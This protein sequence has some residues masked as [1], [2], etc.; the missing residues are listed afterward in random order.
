MNLSQSLYISAC[1]TLYIETKRTNN[2]I[3]HL[4]PVCSCLRDI[5]KLENASDHIDHVSEDFTRR[6]L[7]QTDTKAIDL[8]RFD[9]RH[10]VMLQTLVCR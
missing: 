2:A 4:I 9:G 6:R 10:Y 8:E 1:F 5:H 3:L 7:D